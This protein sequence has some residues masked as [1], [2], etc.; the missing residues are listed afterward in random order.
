MQSSRLSFV[1]RFVLF[2]SVLYRR[3]H[4]THTYTHTYITLSLFADRD[5]EAAEKEEAAERRAQGI[6]YNTV[7]E[8]EHHCFITV[9]TDLRGQ[10]LVCAAREELG[11]ARV[12]I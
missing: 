4:C 8:I 2:R 5:T 1:G 10:I 9:A 12:R 6:L 7:L 11:T 3:F